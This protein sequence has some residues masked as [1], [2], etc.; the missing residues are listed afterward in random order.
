MASNAKYIRECQ[1]C[2]KVMYNVGATK[3]FCAK[4][5]RKH[6][7]LRYYDKLRKE[8]AKA[9]QQGKLY[10]RHLRPRDRRRTHLWPAG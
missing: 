4:C 6:E 2:G 5:L 1:E 9:A 10:Q 8:E 3:L 7:Q